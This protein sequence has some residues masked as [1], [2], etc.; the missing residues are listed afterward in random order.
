[1][2]G[3]SFLAPEAWQSGTLG[4]AASQSP[5]SNEAVARRA[6]LRGPYLS[7]RFFR[8]R[9]NSVSIV[10]FAFD[11]FVRKTLSV[12]AGQFEVDGL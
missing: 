5:R 8:S 10:E 1:M 2:A 9:W 11:P 7:Q 12:K 6:R 4:F 3:K